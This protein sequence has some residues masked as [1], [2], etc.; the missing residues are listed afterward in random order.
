MRALQWYSPQ[1]AAQGV[2]TTVTNTAVLAFASTA[3]VAM[4]IAVPTVLA[5]TQPVASTVAIAG[6]DVTHTARVSFDPISVTTKRVESPTAI[7]A[8]G[9]VT[10]RLGPSS[11]MDRSAEHAVAAAQIT[12]ATH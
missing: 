3:L 1:Q 10:R 7:V 12:G 8:L 5:R 11:A 9:G 6:A 2:A 4:M